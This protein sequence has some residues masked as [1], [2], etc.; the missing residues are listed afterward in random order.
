MS[1]KDYKELRR[2]NPHLKLPQWEKLLP[3]SKDRARQLT[4][5]ELLTSRAAVLL[6]REPGVSDA[7]KT[8]LWS[9]KTLTSK[10]F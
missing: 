2:A 7:L 5:E 3:Q 6:A 10:Q 9:D 1:G 4:Q 8:S